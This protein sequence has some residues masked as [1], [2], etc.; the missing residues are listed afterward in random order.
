MGCGERDKGLFEFFLL[1]KKGSKRKSLQGMKGEERKEGN[2]NQEKKPRRALLATWRLLH[3]ILARGFFEKEKKGS[4]GGEF[5]SKRWGRL[6]R[7]GLDWILLHLSAPG[8]WDQKEGERKKKEVIR[9]YNNAC[10]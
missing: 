4:R 7:T 1:L 8:Q 5:R 2:G 6:T 3:R 9:V 10:D